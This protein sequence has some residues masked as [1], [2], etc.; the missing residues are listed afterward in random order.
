MGVRRDSDFLGADAR[1]TPKSAKAEEPT[2]D[3]DSKGIE[4]R[5]LPRGV[6][7]DEQIEAWI[8]SEYTVRKTVKILDH[9]MVN[10]HL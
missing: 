5:G 4:H 9:E 8:E 10:P 1:T 6:I 2:A 7:T 3:C